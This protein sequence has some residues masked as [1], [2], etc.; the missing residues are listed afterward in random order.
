MATWLRAGALDVVNLDAMVLGITGW[1]RAVA[2]A[3]VEGVAV[4]PHGDQEL[5]V[6]LAAATPA[7]RLVEFYDATNA[8]RRHL[9]TSPA[10]LAPDGTIA[11]PASPGLGVELDEDGAEPFRRGVLEVGAAW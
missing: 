9:F 8:L 3:E 11:V 5:H 7:G 4:A 1:R 6:H 2:L 10:T